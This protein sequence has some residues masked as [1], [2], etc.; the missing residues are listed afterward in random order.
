MQSRDAVW[1][2]VKKHS[3]IGEIAEWV[4]LSSDPRDPGKARC[5]RVQSTA[6]AFLVPM[7]DGHRNSQELKNQLEIHS[8][9]Q[10]TLSNKVDRE[11]HHPRLS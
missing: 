4:N 5:S 11:D 9:K 1:W 10:K 6:P 7:R 3:R 2:S 8:C